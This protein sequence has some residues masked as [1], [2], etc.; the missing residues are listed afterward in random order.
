MGQ[1]FGVVS[2]LDSGQKTLIFVVS[3]RPIVLGP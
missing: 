2:V 3:R 1:G